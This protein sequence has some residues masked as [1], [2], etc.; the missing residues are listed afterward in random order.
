[1]QLFQQLDRLFLSQFSLNEASLL[2]GPLYFHF[3]LLVLLSKLFSPFWILP[4]FPVLNN[5]FNKQISSFSMESSRTIFQFPSYTSLLSSTYSSIASSLLPNLYLYFFL[6]LLPLVL[7]LRLLISTS[8]SY[9]FFLH[10][11][12]QFLLLLFPV[13]TCV[14]SSKF[15][16]LFLPVLHAQSS[17]STSYLWF[18]F[19]F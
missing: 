10:L 11:L 12:L 7:L 18:C 6:Y 17:Y 4:F 5:M 9:F 15:L 8:C 2:Q 13:Y 16:F 19:F 1:M 3:I 14:S